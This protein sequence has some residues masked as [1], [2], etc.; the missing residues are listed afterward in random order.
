MRPRRALSHGFH[1]PGFTPRS[2]C[3][4]GPLT[5]AG[6]DVVRWSHGPSTQLHPA[7]RP[8]GIRRPRRLPRMRRRRAG[9]RRPH[10]GTRP[11][12]PHGLRG[13]PAQAER[14]VARGGRAE[15]AGRFHRGLTSAGRRGRSL[16]LR[17]RGSPREMG[18]GAQVHQPTRKTGRCAPGR[19]DRR[20]EG[21]GGPRS[22][23]AGQARRCCA[24]GRRGASRGGLR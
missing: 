11:L 16:A 12:R 6:D 2:R 9:A 14:A 21:P 23:H 7:P 10:A 19:G 5:N 8:R 17:P 20:A 13:I 3:R 22:T 15:P 4:H 24:R 1:K 18:P